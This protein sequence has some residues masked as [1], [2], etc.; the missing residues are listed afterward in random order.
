[1]SAPW[2]V[3]LNQNFLVS[4]EDEILKSFS[5]DDFD[6]GIVWF[7]DFSWLQELFDFTGLDSLEEWGKVFGSDFI[8]IVN[9]FVIG[10]SEVKDRWGVG[11]V[12]TEIF[13]ESVEESIAV[14]FVWEGEDDSFGVGLVEGSEG[15]LG[16]GRLI[17]TV[18]EEEEGW[19]FILEDFLN[20]VVVEGDDLSVD[21]EDE[22]DG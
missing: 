12:D 18:G 21:E 16:R 17:V 7:W 3:E 22:D 2:G 4:V 1:M 20:G 5:D 15:L 10:S 19:L 13:G 9:V 6:W 8:L 11:G 14:V